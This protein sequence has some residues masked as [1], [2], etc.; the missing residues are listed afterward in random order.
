[1]VYK[2]KL[3]FLLLL[4]FALYQ[5]EEKAVWSDEFNYEGLPDPNK[6]TYDVGNGCPRLC[7]WGNNEVQVYTENNL[8][9]ARVEDGKLIIEAHKQP[10][11][12]WTS[13]RL[14]TQGKRHM[15]YGKAVIRAK[16]PGGA[17]VWSAIWMLGENITTKGWPAC[18]EIDIMEHVGKN[19]GYVHSALHSPSSYGA[20]ENTGISKV[21]GF[22][23][24]FHD[25]GFEWSPEKITVYI[26]GRLHYEYAPTEKNADTWPFDD[27]FFFI[28]NIAMGGNWG[29][30]VSLETNGRK[31]GIDPELTSARMEIDHIRVYE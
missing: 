27:P 11:G 10:D 15:R 18:G 20:T 17:G 6:W 24:D 12:S 26:D 13:A 30:E 1:M 9:N 3:L 22:D 31:N 5:C 21:P 28:F 23:T 16:I 25:Y 2:Q 19:P 8:A 4:C 29:S 7:G 14:K